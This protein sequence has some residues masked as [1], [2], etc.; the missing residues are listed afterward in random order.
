MPELPPPPMSAFAPS[1]AIAR[2]EGPPPPP[3]GQDFMPARVVPDAVER[4]TSL[5]DLRR[6]YPFQRFFTEREALTRLLKDSGSLS[7]NH[8]AMLTAASSTDERRSIWVSMAKNLAPDIGI[9]DPVDQNLFAVSVA[10]EKDGLGG[11]DDLIRDT[12]IMNVMVYISEERESQPVV[13]VH[14]T[15]NSKENL[16]I[17]ITSGWDTYRNQL[18]N[19]A[20]RLSRKQIKL[21][22]GHTYIEMVLPDGPE[23]GARFVSS[24][25]EDGR[26]ISTSMRLNRVGSPDLRN[27]RDSGFIP[28]DELYDFLIALVY[29][30]ANALFVGPQQSGK[31]TL[32][33]GFVN[34][35]PSTDEVL[36]VED[37]PELMIEQGPRHEY[38]VSQQ[39][40]ADQTMTTII[41]RAMRYVVKRICVGEAI[42]AAITNWLFASIRLRGGACTIHADAIDGVFNAIRTLSTLVPAG[43]APMPLETLML[44]VAD[45]LDI[46]VF[47][48]P[49]PQKDDPLKSF[50]SIKA[51]MAIDGK[52]SDSGMPKHVIMWDWNEQTKE[53]TWQGSQ[54]PD[55]LKERLARIGLA[56]D[57]NTARMRVV[58][59]QKLPKGLYHLDQE[60][61]AMSRVDVRG[62]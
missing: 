41:S 23:K 46:V 59:R 32:L 15:D 52:L 20:I 21:D 7:N 57:S 18:M 44:S 27:L 54:M 22:Q 48:A 50:P 31:T 8:Q 51:V 43:V 36:I 47:L 35:F 11:L 24:L 1:T 42:D 16:P 53:L 60:L 56:L 39:P 38:C 61:S 34:S 45:C 29:A 55:R 4:T 25:V 58:D 13:R 12:D 30:N 17:R 33:R 6:K 14:Y 40:T 10:D 19:N 5:D 28:T 3:P 62:F 37:I 49:E 26:A 9:H 2:V